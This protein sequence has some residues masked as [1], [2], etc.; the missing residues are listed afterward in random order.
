MA[1]AMRLQMGKRGPM[2]HILYN[3][4]LLKGHS[5]SLNYTRKAL[6]LASLLRR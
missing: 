3:I 6:N 2:H 4:L 5:Y 1:L